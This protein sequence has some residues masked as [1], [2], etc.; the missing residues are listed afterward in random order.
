VNLEA[1]VSSIELNSTSFC[2]VLV[3]VPSMT[4]FGLVVYFIDSEACIVSVPSQ[5][6]TFFSL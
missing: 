6:S 3:H 5:P 1:V 2:R 4:L